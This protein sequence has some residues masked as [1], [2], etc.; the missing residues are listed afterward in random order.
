M[1]VLLHCAFLFLKPETLFRPSAVGCDN[2][3]SLSL[4]VLLIQSL[5][6]TRQQL[7]HLHPSMPLS[8]ILT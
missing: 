5:S 2:L 4:S 7:T 1:E 6:F 3:W 8:G